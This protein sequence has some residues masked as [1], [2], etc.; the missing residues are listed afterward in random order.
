MKKILGMGNALVDILVKINDDQ[1]LEKYELPKGSM[2]LVDKEKSQQLI[3]ALRHLK[4]EI[5]SGGSAANTINGLANLDIPCG[6]IGKIHEDKFGKI[7]SDDMTSKGIEAVLFNGS[8]DTGIATTLISEDSQRTFATF[9]GSA[10]EMTPEDLKEEYFAGYDYFHIEGYLVQ[11]HELI[12]AAVKLAKKSGLKVSIDMASYNVVEDNLQFLKK[13]VS[14]YVDIV[15]ANEEESKSFTGKEPE[16]AMIDIAEMC[17]ISVVKVGAQGSMVMTKNE[18]VSVGVINANPIDTTGAGDL[19]AAGFLYGLANELSLEKCAKLGSL[20]GGNVIEV[21]G[22]KMD[23][24]R[25]AGIKSGVADI[26]S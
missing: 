7:F 12:E 1:L 16:A 13:L 8:Q 26:I 25:W 6:Y 22:P 10:V 20:L 5:A 24:A 18:K 21:I 14:E 4:Y 23:E 3:N 9:L 11:N 15:F 19:Y 17:D 2:Q